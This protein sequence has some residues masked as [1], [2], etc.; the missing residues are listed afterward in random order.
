MKETFQKR[1]TA[2]WV[3]LQVYFF[4]VSIIGL[5]FYFLFFY[6]QLLLPSYFHCLPHSNCFYLG[7]VSKSS[8]LSLWV[9]LFSH[10]HWLCSCSFAFALLSSSKSVLVKMYFLV[11]F[12]WDF[13]QPACS[14]FTFLFLCL[15]FISL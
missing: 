12:L 6:F 14:T 3:L 5:Q 13:L 4:K 9:G 15:F 10:G 8:P 1:S 2:V 7:L 11:D